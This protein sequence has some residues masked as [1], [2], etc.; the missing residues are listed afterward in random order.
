MPSQP[1]ASRSSGRTSPAWRTALLAAGLAL[2]G[3]SLFQYPSQVRGNRIEGYTLKEL[4]PGTSTRADAT[5]LL[6]SPTARA[7]FNDNQWIYIGETTRPLIGRTQG[8]L[9]QTVVVLTFNDQGVLQ[10]VEQRDKGDALPVDVVSRTTPSPGSEASALQ[11]LLGNIGRFN[12]G[13]LG[14]SSGGVPVGG[15]APSSDTRT[16]TRY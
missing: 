16:G 15:A 13:G 12:P 1:H 3:C 2:S 4:T 8:V 6:G 5:A 9:S 7:T 11:Q 14:G 10:N